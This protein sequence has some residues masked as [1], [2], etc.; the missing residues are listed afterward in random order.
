MGIERHRALHLILEGLTEELQDAF[1]MPTSWSAAGYRRHLSQLSRAV[2]A[3]DQVRTVQG[4][5][6][7]RN[8]PCP[9][10][11][12]KKY[13]RCCGSFDAPLRLA[14]ERGR[15]ILGAGFYATYGYLQQ[16]P[17]G[18]PVL[19]LENLAAVARA[20]E[21]VSLPAVAG[22]AYRRLVAAADAAGKKDCLQNALRE[23]EDLAMNHLECAADGIKAAQRLMELTDDPRYLAQLRLDQA[24]LYDAAGDH[25]RA[26]SL[27]R[28]VIAEDPPEPYCYLR[29][30]RWLAEAG[31]LAE[32][33]TVYRGVIE[34][35]GLGDVDAVAEASQELAE[36]LEQQRR[37]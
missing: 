36:L 6:P 31:N 4:R 15:M 26:E 32:A 9:C 35:D 17:D 3:N 18:D 27:F 25:D 2:I 12:G 5:V 21:Q 22:K 11:S 37:K 7:G 20:L 19:Y 33:E 23:L 30:A 16:A 34:R 10:G 14:P 1:E 29:W 24:V 28:A 8:E 13:K